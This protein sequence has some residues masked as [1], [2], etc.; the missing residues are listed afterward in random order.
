MLLNGTRVKTIIAIDI[1]S[2]I[3]YDD[4]ICS[5]SVCHVRCWFPVGCY[6][7]DIDAVLSDDLILECMQYRSCHSMTIPKGPKLSA[8]ILWYVFKI[9]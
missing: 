1:S 2:S 8:N 5:T 9:V 6:F 4:I 3:S 7:V